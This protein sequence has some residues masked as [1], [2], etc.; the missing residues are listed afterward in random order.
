MGEEQRRVRAAVFVPH[1]T[2]SSIAKIDYDASYRFSPTTIVDRISDI[3]PTKSDYNCG[4]C[5]VASFLN[6]FGFKTKSIDKGAESFQP[7]EVIKAF[8]DASFKRFNSSSTDEFVKHLV[9]QGDGAGGVIYGYYKDKDYRNQGHY[10]AY[11]IYKGT[12]YLMDGQDGSI[13]PS[14]WL[15][16]MMSPR[17]LSVARLDGLDIDPILLKEIIK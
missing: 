6:S 1:N 12:A 13:V 10:L 7:F 4:S 16:D 14:S 11:H 15:K 17:T 2:L 3:N 8:K 5:A 9:S